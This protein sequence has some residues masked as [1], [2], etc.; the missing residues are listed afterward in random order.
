MSRFGRHFVR[1]REIKDFERRLIRLVVNKPGA[2]N[3]QHEALLRYGAIFARQHLFRTPEGVD[4][5]L[6]SE[7][8]DFRRWFHETL[9]PLMPS[10]KEPDIN[11]LR[12]QTQALSHRLDA[13][14][15][16]LLAHHIN[17]F[18]PEHLDDELR[19]KKL[20]LALG[21][22][23][24]AGLAH[25]GTFSLFNELGVVPELIAG[26]SMGSIMGALRAIDR[27]YDPVATALAL[28]KDLNYNTVF[29]P[30]S[31]YSRFG[32][33]GAFHM[34]L[35]RVA[36]EIFKQLTGSPTLNFNDLPIKLQVIVTGIRTGFHL[37]EREYMGHNDSFS[38][39]TIRS[40][41]KTFFRVIRQISSNPRFLAQLVFGKETGTE[42]FSVVEAVGFSCAV[43]GLLHYDIYHDDPTIIEP[44]ERLFE[45]HQLL[46]MCDGGVVNNVPAQVVWDSVQQGAIGT[47]NAFI[48]SC[49]VFAPISS[50]RNLLWIPIQ[51][52][53]RQNVLANKPYSDYHKTFNSPPSP[54]QVIV[55]QY[56]RLKTI[57]LSAR[58]ELEEDEPYLKRALRPLP[59]YG[60]WLSSKDRLLPP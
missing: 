39:L 26:S 21:G 51:Q 38:S 46:R 36:K 35:L 10:G 58:Q 60:V 19:H 30:F 4:V 57:I 15:R 9:T 40:R 55:N 53:A 12:A 25:L 45:Q 28:P 11:A 50:G 29:K 3:E 47:R 52:I 7:V 42:A 20:V 6:A 49:D 27:S 33:P 48:M 32:F 31:G 24:G 37:D 22:G 18:G 14:R 17:D 43:P 23:G 44:L 59:P 56:S 1:T 16:A 8:E 34:N 13:T 41:L 5:D 2:L 54:L